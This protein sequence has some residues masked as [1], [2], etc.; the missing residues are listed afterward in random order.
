MTKPIPAGCIKGYPSPS[1]K[2]FNLLIKSVSQDDKI[3]IFLWLIL[4]LI[5]KNATE[6]EIL[7]NENYRQF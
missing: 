2:K 7:Y 3:D 6:G 1:W 4:S 5:E